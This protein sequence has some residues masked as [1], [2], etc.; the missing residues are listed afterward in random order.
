[1]ILMK[2]FFC[3]SIFAFLITVFGALS[4]GAQ[5]IEETFQKEVFIQGV[6]TLRYRIL[7]PENFSEDKTYPV[8]LFLHG[9]GERGN[10][11]EAQLIHGGKLFLEKNNEFPSIVIFPQAPLNDFWA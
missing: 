6:D 1:N 2:T 11:N 9:A 8:V 10:D 3:K 4:A 5:T 7:Y